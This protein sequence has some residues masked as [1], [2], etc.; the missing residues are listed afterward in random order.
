MLLY[1]NNFNISLVKLNFIGGY[2]FLF[3]FFFFFFD[4]HKSI[5]SRSLDFE[6]GIILLNQIKQARSTIY[7]IYAVGMSHLKLKFHNLSSSITYLWFPLYVNI[8]SL[9]NFQTLPTFNLI[10]K[11]ATAIYLCYRSII[12]N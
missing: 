12:N 6:T 5:E 11:L 9:F 8:T 7:N 1:S 10:N 4:Y 3:N 2:F